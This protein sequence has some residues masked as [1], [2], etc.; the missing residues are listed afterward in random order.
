MSWPETDNVTHL[1]DRFF[2]FS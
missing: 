1:P 2:F